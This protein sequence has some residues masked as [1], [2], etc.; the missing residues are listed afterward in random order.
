MNRQRRKEIGALAVRAAEIVTLID[1]LKEDLETV[2]DEEQEY[3][4]NMPESL[5][6]GE[7]GD[8]AQAAIEQMDEA[9]EA[10]ESLSDADPE[11]LLN[12]AAE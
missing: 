6:G 2:R 3:F 11:S 5:Q 8:M 7:K 12:T 4:D 10:L 9:I 1:D